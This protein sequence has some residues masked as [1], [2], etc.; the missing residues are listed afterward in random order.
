MVNTL[1]AL[2][3]L[4]TRVARAGRY[5]VVWDTMVAQIEPTSHVRRKMG[6]VSEIGI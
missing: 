5:W 4:C 1:C 2:H 6:W 3:A